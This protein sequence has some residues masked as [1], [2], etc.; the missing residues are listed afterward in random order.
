MVRDIERRVCCCKKWK[1]QESRKIL[2][3]EK[4]YNH[5][6]DTNRTIHLPY[7]SGHPAFTY[8]LGMAIL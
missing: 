1:L 2:L 7:N 6:H 8:K 4:A 5:I 3:P